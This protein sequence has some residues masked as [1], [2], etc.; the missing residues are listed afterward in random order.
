M[1]YF[2]S[3][4]QFSPDKENVGNDDYRK[5]TTFLHDLT[6]G[7]AELLFKAFCDHSEGNAKMPINRRSKHD[8]SKMT[9]TGYRLL[10]VF[11]YEHM[12][13]LEEFGSLY[14]SPIPIEENQLKLKV[15]FWLPEYLLV[16]MLLPNTY[17]YFCGMPGGFLDFSKRKNEC[18]SIHGVNYI[19]IYYG[20]IVLLI[21]EKRIIFSKQSEL[22]FK[23]FYSDGNEIRTDFLHFPVQ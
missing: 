17:H 10:C 1:M 5:V 6:L 7:P 21:Y 20:M 15:D 16:E 3:I 19:S 11:L 13:M 22:I 8:L 12:K 18:D 23:C 2:Q 14:I 4:F 9:I